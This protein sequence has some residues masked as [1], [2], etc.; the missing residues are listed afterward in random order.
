MAAAVVLTA[1]EA[2]VAAAKV[3]LAAADTGPS[4]DELTDQ[5]IAGARVAFKV[6]AELR[7]DGGAIRAGDSLSA[8]DS[9]KGEV[10]GRL[11]N[12]RL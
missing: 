11:R 10:Q 3:A 8:S 2:D 7:D 9:G 1:R 12:D 6:L 4:S 5:D